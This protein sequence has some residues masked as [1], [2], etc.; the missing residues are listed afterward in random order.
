MIESTTVRSPESVKSLIL[1]YEQRGKGQGMKRK[2][3]MHNNLSTF[4]YVVESVSRL[5]DAWTGTRLACRCKC[6]NAKKGRA[7]E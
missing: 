7:F 6:V 3:R 1:S 4:G 5:S 2:N